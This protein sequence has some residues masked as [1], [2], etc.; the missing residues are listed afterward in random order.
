[1]DPH[2]I[3]YPPHDRIFYEKAA[4]LYFDLR[5]QGVTIRNSIDVLIALTAIENNLMLLHNDC[6]FDAIADMTASLQILKTLPKVC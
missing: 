4:R 2:Y 5:R 6:D 1:M 3:Y